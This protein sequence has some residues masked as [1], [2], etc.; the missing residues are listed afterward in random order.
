[1]DDQDA[2]QEPSAAIEETTG[3]DGNDDVD[4]DPEAVNEE[5]DI[6]KG[7]N[8]E[9]EG[10]LCI[11]LTYSMYFLRPPI[12][13]FLTIIIISYNH[14]IHCSHRGSYSTRIDCNPSP[15]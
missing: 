9:P 10:E 13:M 2:A 5:P 8:T 4:V 14:R 1:M 6:E 12:T 15:R 3:N 11:A 7:I